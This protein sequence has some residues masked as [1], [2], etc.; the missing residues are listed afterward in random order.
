MI[1]SRTFRKS[2]VTPVCV[3]VVL[4][5][6]VSVPVAARRQVQDST[7][8]RSAQRNPA[9]Q[10]VSRSQA[11]RA[12][13]RSVINNV[14]PSLRAKEATDFLLTPALL[15]QEAVSEKS[16]LTYPSE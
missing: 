5:V 11:E 9:R 6:L 10:E 16:V 13:G 8:E 2:S 7:G 14:A 1:T 15:M 3:S 4:A 12:A